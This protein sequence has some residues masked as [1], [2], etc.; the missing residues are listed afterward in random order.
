MPGTSAISGLVS[1]L[2]TADLIDQL[3]AVSRRR[4]DVVVTN[5]TEKK[6]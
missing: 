4:I 2:D 5:Q 3:I 1:G 6:W